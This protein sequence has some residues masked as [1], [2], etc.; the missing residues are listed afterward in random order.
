MKTDR[1]CTEAKRG[2]DRYSTDPQPSTPE[3]ARFDKTLDAWVLT[4]YAD[5]LRALREPGLCQ[6][7]PRSKHRS[8]TCDKNAQSRRRAK[9]RAALPYWRLTEWQRQMQ[10]LA[11][12]MM[13]QLPKGRSI[14]LLSEFVR[15]WSLAVTLAIIGADPVHSQRLADLAHYLP[16]GEIDCNNAVVRSRVARAVAELK[17]SFRKGVGITPVCESAFRVLSHS[18]HGSIATASFVLPKRAAN[19]EFEKLD[20]RGALGLGKS[21]FLGSSQTIPLFLANAWRA[22]FLHPAELVRLCAEPSLMPRAVEE[23]LRYAGVVHTLFRRATVK[24]DIGGGKISENQRVILK[25]DSANRDPAQF[26]EPDRL[27]VARRATGQL[28][29]GAGPNSCA[30]ASLVRIAAAVA[31][32][33]LIGKFVVAE[34]DGPVE[35]YSNST[36]YSPASLR[37]LLRSRMT[38]HE[39]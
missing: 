37:V 9:V 22:L 39:S 30:G 8:G 2:L 12:T 18:L 23:L 32:T 36:V 13:D 34:M 7:G 31:T 27:D 25:L 19:T 17:S 5:V 14:D 1:S 15:P 16:G 28:A 38:G 26:P 3:A 21:V 29:L 6:V 11:D 10:L 33:A 24:V 4:R 20:R 35:W